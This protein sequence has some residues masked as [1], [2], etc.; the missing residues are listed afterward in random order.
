MF[1][2][3]ILYSSSSL[4]PRNIITFSYVSICCLDGYLIVTGSFYSEESKIS[5]ALH[6]SWGANVRI[7]CHTLSFL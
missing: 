5:R 4:Y 2:L 6:P 3:Y 1:L 7:R